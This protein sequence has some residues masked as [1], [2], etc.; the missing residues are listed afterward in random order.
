MYGYLFVRVKNILLSNIIAPPHLP[1]KDLSN[2]VYVVYLIITC[3]CL[4]NK[5]QLALCFGHLYMLN[6]DEWDS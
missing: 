6:K 2:S 4:G 1:K 3:C 5:N